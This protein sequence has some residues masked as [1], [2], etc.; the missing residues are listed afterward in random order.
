MT[1]AFRTLYYHALTLTATP[2][3]PPHN[4]GI[5]TVGVSTISSLLPFHLQLREQV[6]NA[7]IVVSPLWHESGN[8]HGL[9]WDEKPNR[10]EWATAQTLNAPPR[11]RCEHN[12]IDFMHL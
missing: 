5:R 3:K 7:R 8:I 4:N 2:I 11:F 12:K 1:C 10:L 9:V 6:Y